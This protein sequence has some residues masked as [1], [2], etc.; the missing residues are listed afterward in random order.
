M[1]WLHLLFAIL[2][3][4][5]ATSTLKATAGFTRAVPTLVVLVGYV[6]SFY[7]LSRALEAIPLA[8]AYST[9]SGV[10]AVCVALIGRVV[11][12]QPITVEVV[13]GIL[14][15]VAGVLTLQ[16]AAHNAA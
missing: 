11:Y 4:V 12:Q 1:H 6:L 3:E 10:G 14:L 7:L 9:W 2:A 15:V 5:A 13:I 8:I 16:T